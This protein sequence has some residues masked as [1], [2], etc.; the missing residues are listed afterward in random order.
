VNFP[1]DFDVFQVKG[2][3]EGAQPMPTQQTHHGGRRPNSG[4]KR[5][6]DVSTMRTLLVQSISDTQWDRLAQKLYQRACDGDLQAAELLIEYRFGGPEPIPTPKEE[7][8]NLIEY[9]P[10]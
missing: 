8:I 4:R 6:I 7:Q 9:I 2:K 3:L 5:K 1:L 10:M